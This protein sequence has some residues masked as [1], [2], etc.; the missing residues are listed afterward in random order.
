MSKEIK[1]CKLCGDITIDDHFEGVDGE[2]SIPVSMCPTLEDVATYYEILVGATFK[3]NT[4]NK[5]KD[6]FEKRF[7]EASHESYDEL[8][9]EEAK[10]HTLEPIEC[11]CEII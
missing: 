11:W 5:I 1:K 10:K 3:Q 4:G 6:S 9:F 8:G 2:M 7:I